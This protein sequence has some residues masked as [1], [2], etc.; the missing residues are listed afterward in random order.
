MKQTVEAIID[1]QGHVRLVEPVN[2]KGLHRALVTILDEPPEALSE[3]A[4]LA[5]K[6]RAQDWLHE[7][8]DQAWPQEVLNFQGVPDMPSFESYRSEL[9]PP[10]DDP[11]A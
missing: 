7:E 11:L 4:Q 10:K 6:S 5:E 8:G 9:A 2:I 3:A 1:E